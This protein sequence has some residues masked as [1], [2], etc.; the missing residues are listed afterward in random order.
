M[1]TVKHNRS[2]LTK[3]E[4][5]GEGVAITGLFTLMIIF[6]IA[7]AAPSFLNQL[8]IRLVNEMSENKEKKFI[9]IS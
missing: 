4:I 1:C 9:I 7:Y 3:T 6:I 5:T 2:P 8:I